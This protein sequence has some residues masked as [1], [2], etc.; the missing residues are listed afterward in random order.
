MNNNGFAKRI[1]DLRRS[2]NL[3]Q[4]ELGKIVD[5][6]YT[7]IG[8]YER[9]Q[10]KPS[11]DTLKKLAD[12]FGV[13]TDYII[14]GKI[15]KAAQAKLEDKDLLDMFKE[16]ENFSEEDKIVVKRFLNAFINNK[17]IHQLTHP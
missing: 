2:K 16:I 12:A 5:L 1:R 11:S 10:S 17:K 8:R 3:S 13:T 6:H 14:E 4:I 9:G 15:D 7:H